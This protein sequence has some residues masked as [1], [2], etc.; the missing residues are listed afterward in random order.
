MR[1]VP[2]GP[3]AAPKALNAVK[4]GQTELDRARAHYAKRGPR[5]AYEFTVYKADEVK[6]RLEELFHGKCAYC[7]TVYASTAPV[8]VE[9]YRPKGRVEGEP[10][11]HGYWWLAMAWDNLLPSCIDCNRRRKQVVPK[12][13]TASLAQLDEAARS[14]TGTRVT[15][16]G[17]KDLFPIAGRRAGAEIDS[18]SAEAP[19]L[20]NPCEDDPL[21]HLVFHVEPKDVIGLV[22]PRQ[23]EPAHP[24]APPGPN[25]GDPVLA[26]SRR[27]A[28]SIQV[29]GLNRL[30]LVQERTRILRR[31]EFL[32]WM[33]VELGVVIQSLAAKADPD[34]QQAVSRLRLLQDRILAE[35]RTMAAPTEPYSAMV[36]EWI[37][38]FRSRLR[39]KV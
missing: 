20:L 18:L 5:K 21:Q 10:T 34:V 24:E 38:G 22:L 16:A 13:G 29:Y 36:S 7:E 2:R 37:E 15:L 12:D 6:R 25:E 3:V 35:M 28:V 9:H 17:K 23:V 8:D 4:S 32:E 14:T 19:L 26:A 39:P 27:G 31:L 33:T 11:H 30:G 1:S